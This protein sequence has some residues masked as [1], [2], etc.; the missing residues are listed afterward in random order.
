MTYVF[1]AHPENI[2]PERSPGDPGKFSTISA[3][4][5]G[6]KSGRGF[7]TPIGVAQEI[8]IDEHGIRSAASRPR[9]LDI[10]CM[11]R[12]DRELHLHLRISGTP[13][14]KIGS[15]VLSTIRSRARSYL[16]NVGLRMHG[17]TRSRRTTLAQE[18]NPTAK[19]DF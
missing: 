17:R 6:D 1:E 11:L 10:R 19:N 5:S 12:P 14:L 13:M 8:R 2:R 4:A 18:H 7:A 16:T 3:S 15:D 9:L